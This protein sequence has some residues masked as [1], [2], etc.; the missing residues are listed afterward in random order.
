MQD[1]TK[2]LVIAG[3]DPSAGAGLLMDLKVI[4]KLGGYA[5][6]IP[7]CLTVQDTEKVYKV[8][9]LPNSYFKESLNKIY[10]DIININAVKIGALFSKEIIKDLINFLKEIKLKNITF[11]PVLF[12][13]QGVPLIQED[14]TQYIGELINFCDVIT[15]N[16]KE[17]EIISEIKIH[18]INDMQKSAIKIREIYE[19]KSVIIKGGHLKSD[20]IYDLL[21]DGKE[22]HTFKRK[23]IKDLELHGSGCI[24]SSAIAYFLAKTK[25]IYKA[26][27][28]SEK[29]MTKIL[30]NTLKIGKGKSVGDI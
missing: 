14:A 1:K 21:Y 28:L 20:Q 30:K 8:Y 9:P 12:P 23:R 24:F 4:H 29:F 22:F 2:I 13:T 6:C 16:I 18:N 11:D 3:Y 5:L 15:P 25:D 19:V 27:I 7:T 10:G 26:F 17:A